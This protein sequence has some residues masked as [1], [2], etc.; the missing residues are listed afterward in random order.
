LRPT[1]STKSDVFAYSIVCFEVGH[2]EIAYEG[3]DRSEI[4][5]AISTDKTRLDISEEVPKA[6]ANLIT[7]CW[8]HLPASRPTFQEVIKY[9]D[10]CELNGDSEIPKGT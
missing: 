8:E 2:W 4:R 10:K 3:I 6:L 5:H 9:L 1:F 7:T